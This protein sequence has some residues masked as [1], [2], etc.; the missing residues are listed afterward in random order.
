MHTE[1]C[2][3]WADRIARIVADV[4]KFVTRAEAKAH[5]DAKEACHACQREAIED[6]LHE[7]D[8]STR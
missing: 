4:N 5:D 3:K 2:K 7:M 1:D 6:R 8:V